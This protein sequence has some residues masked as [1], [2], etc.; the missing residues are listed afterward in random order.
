MTQGIN[1]VWHLLGLVWA[2]LGG[3]GVGEQMTHSL[4]REQLSDYW[5][6]ELKQEYS[7]G[8]AT[9]AHCKIV[10]I[11]HT[12]EILPS[13]G[14]S[15]YL[16][17]KLYYARDRP[18]V[19]DVSDRF[20]S[21][22]IESFDLSSTEFLKAVISE[23]I[24]HVK[25]KIVESNCLYLLAFLSSEAEIN[26]EYVS[27]SQDIRIAR[28]S[29]KI[30][31]N[32]NQSLFR[33]DLEFPNDNFLSLHQPTSVHK[34]LHVLC[35]GFTEISGKLK[36][37]IDF[38]KKVEQS[39][40]QPNENETEAPGSNETTGQE[41]TPTS[42]NEEANQDSTDANKPGENSNNNNND[43]NNNGNNDNNTSDNISNN[44]SNGS[45]NNEGSADQSQNETNSQP[46]SESQ[47]TKEQITPKSSE[48]LETLN[49]E[50]EKEF[51][52][53]V[54]SY[55]EE[56]EK[57]NV[58]VIEESENV[59]DTDSTQDK[60]SSIIDSPNGKGKEIV[61]VKTVK[62]AICNNIILHY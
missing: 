13:D 19:R 44:N 54:I 32:P 20:K 12:G 39:E 48:D 45:S 31:E 21:D 5:Y 29:T 26:L 41:D 57:E 60:N 1:S 23:P 25:I 14:F 4:G 15:Y 11:D 56:K 62:T 36:V 52:Q 59:K 42:T 22:G 6:N 46:E 30:F 40:P 35:V 18:S 49:S 51:I 58:I 7:L 50:Q 10:G 37:D 27:L 53:N 55:F 61:T 33:A 3:L 38:A 24:G 34:N 16:P 47:I 17:N 43:S 28:S 9:Q 8:S 2:L